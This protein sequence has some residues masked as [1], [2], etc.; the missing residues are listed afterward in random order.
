M[1]GVIQAGNSESEQSAEAK[2]EEGIYA[3]FNTVTIKFRGRPT[4]RLKGLRWCEECGH[5]LCTYNFNTICLH[6][7]TDQKKALDLVL[8]DLYKYKSGSRSY[9]NVFTK[10]QFKRITRRWS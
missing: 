4:K 1:A 2:L 8:E 5:K 10:N 9:R 7:F 6:H 3:G